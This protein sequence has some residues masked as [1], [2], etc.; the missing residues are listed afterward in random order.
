MATKKMSPSKLA[1][2]KRMV[3]AKFQLAKKKLVVAERR[4]EGYVKKNPKRAVGIAAAVGAA[5]GAA[6]AYALMRRKK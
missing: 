6:T 2:A 1:Q 4:A 3:K 5:I